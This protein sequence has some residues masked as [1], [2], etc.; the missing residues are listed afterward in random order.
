MSD[1]PIKEALEA[2]VDG[3]WFCNHYIVVAA[4]Q[5]FSDEDHYQTATVLLMAPGQPEY[6]TDGLLLRGKKIQEL[7]PQSITDVL[8]DD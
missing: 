6:V 5:K 2:T 3:D 7:P 8:G 1:D 4:Y